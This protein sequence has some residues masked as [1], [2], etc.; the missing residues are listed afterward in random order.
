MDD[1]GHARLTDFGFAAIAP[2]LGSTKLTTE[3]HAVRWAAPEV[4]DRELP[5]SKKSDVY[6]FAM[7]MFEVWTRY[8]IPAE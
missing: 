4:L 5:V 7:V 1:T 3:G 2:E 6:S 8:F